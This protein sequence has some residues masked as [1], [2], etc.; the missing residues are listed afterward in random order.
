ME[1]SRS[2]LRGE[3]EVW[4]RE[5]APG[6]RIRGSRAKSRR[7]DL[8]PAAKAPQ[9]D[10]DPELRAR[11][12]R[13]FERGL[14]E[15]QLVLLASELDSELDVLVSHFGRELGAGGHGLGVLHRPRQPGLLL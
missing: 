15:L 8:A 2:V 1:S 5:E 7:G 11:L 13:V 3:T 12:A 4:L 10:V 6:T 9:G 14:E